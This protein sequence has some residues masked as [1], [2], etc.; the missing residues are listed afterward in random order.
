MPKRTKKITIIALVLYALLIT[1]HVFAA[2]KNDVKPQGTG[3]ESALY[4]FLSVQPGGFHESVIVDLTEMAL[5]S[6]AGAGFYLYLKNNNTF[7]NVQQRINYFG[8]FKQGIKHT[9]LGAV[10]LSLLTNLYELI[11]INWFYYPFVYKV[12]SAFLS[13]SGNTYFSSNSLVYIISYIALAAIGWGIF[14]LLVFGIGLF[15]KKNALILT[16]GPITGLLLIILPI[17]GSKGSKALQVL[18]ISSFFY[19]LISPGQENSSVQ[20]QPINS[21]L[22]YMLAVVIYLLIA[23]VLIKLWQ[24][25]QVNKG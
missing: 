15:V 17:L 21:I 7:S 2:I 8:F 3:L 18:S 12:K 9:F 6:S 23:L 20:Y 22:A 1:W 10:S 5:M 4:L 24:K 19:T 16:I 14:A 11:L 13:N 25:Q